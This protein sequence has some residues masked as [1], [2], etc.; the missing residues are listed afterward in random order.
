M[1][2]AATMPRDATWADAFP[3]PSSVTLAAVV[4]ALVLLGSTLHVKSLIRERRNPSFARASRAYAAGCLALSP[5]VASAWG[6]PQGWW[7]VVPFAAAF[8]RALAPWVGRRPGVIG[9]TEAA[10]FVLTAV[11]AFA[12]A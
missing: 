12:A 5:V 2:L 4:C 7:W 10:L 8:A 1:Y 11:C 6:L 9:G 3:L